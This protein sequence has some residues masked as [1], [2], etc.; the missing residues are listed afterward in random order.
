M[1]IPDDA[2]DYEPDWRLPL[3]RKQVRCPNTREL[4]RTCAAPRPSKQGRKANP[5]ATLGV[6][7]SI[8]LGGGEAPVAVI[9]PAINPEARRP[10]VR[11]YAEALAR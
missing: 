7:E 8:G 6:C 5:T 3:W 11:A 2:D 10:E 4:R 1:A 9:P